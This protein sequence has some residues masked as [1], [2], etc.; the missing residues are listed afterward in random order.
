MF[1][2]LN[3]MVSLQVD[4]KTKQLLDELLTIHAPLFVAPKESRF[5]RMR[6]TDLIYKALKTLKKEGKR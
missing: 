4:D 6:N 5:R 3:E 1:Q 2:D